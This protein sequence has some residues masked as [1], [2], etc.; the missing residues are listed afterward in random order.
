MTKRRKEEGEMKKHEEYMAE[1]IEIGKG[2]PPFPFGT[3]VVNRTTG[4]VVAKGL[5]DT[6]RRG[7]IWHGEMDAIENVAKI[8]KV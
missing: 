2:C 3:V 8:P 5:N 7:P 1:A 6:R 4:Q